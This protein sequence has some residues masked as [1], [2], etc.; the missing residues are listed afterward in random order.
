LRVDPS[1]KTHRYLAQKET[2]ETVRAEPL[3][4]KD[5]LFGLSPLRDNAK[6]TRL[7]LLALQAFCISLD[8]LF[9]SID[10]LI[11]KI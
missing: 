3:G 6:T 10:C 8:F 4:N 9:S 2:K 5:A 1:T 7:N 11:Q